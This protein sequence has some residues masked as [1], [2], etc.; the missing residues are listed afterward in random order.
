MRVIATKT[1]Y[2][3]KVREPGDEFEVPA[4]TSGSWFAPVKT[5]EKP[6]RGKKGEADAEQGD[7]EA[8]A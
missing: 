3:G 8:L 4:G 7:G 2:F 6:A 1:G 5:T